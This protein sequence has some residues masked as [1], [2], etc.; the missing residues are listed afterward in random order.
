MAALKSL[1]VTDASRICIQMSAELLWKLE[2]QKSKLAEEILIT[3]E[4]LQEQVKL[5]IT[6]KGITALVALAFLADV[7]EIRRF[8]NSRKMNAYLGV[9]P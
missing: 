4:P 1:D 8:R 6:I 3:G 9:V 7:G 5:L 2:E